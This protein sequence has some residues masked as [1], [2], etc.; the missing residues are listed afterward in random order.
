MVN[1]WYA[2]RDLRIPQFCFCLCSPT[3]DSKGFGVTAVK[4]WNAVGEIQFLDCSHLPTP[5]PSQDQKMGLQLVSF[6]FCTAVMVPSYLVPCAFS[7]C[8][9]LTVVKGPIFLVNIFTVS[10]CDFYPNIDYNLTKLW[11]SQS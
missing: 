6:T 7:N 10:H 1:P 3:S 11:L 8:L 4:I 5:S 2:H 9:I